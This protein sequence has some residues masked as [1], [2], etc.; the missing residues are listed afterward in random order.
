[1]SMKVNGKI[2]AR[3]REEIRWFLALGPSSVSLVKV[4]I[5]ENILCVCD[6]LYVSG[7][8]RVANVEEN[9]KEEETQECIC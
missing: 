3:K 8:D 6:I 1:M 4:V 9:R 2:R 5:A 7:F